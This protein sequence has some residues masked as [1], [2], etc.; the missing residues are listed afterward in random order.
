MQVKPIFDIVKQL[1]ESLLL[2]VEKLLL[3]TLPEVD[4]SGY[5]LIIENVVPKKNQADY[6]EVMGFIDKP[7]SMIA[8]SDTGGY[9][10]NGKS[11]TQ[12][13]SSLGLVNNVQVVYSPDVLGVDFG[14]VLRCNF[15]ALIYCPQPKEVVYKVTEA[16]FAVSD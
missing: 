15:S 13:N 4:F 16:D 9:T 8:G 3:M 7:V 14:F 5:I 6:F 10:L 11:I 1:A 2:P 12:N